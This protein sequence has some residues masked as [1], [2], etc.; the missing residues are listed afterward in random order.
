MPVFIDDLLSRVEKPARY[1]GGEMNATTKSFDDADVTFAFC[2]PDTYEVAMSHLGMKILYGILNDL[3]YALC[4][5]VCMPWTDMR[6][7]LKAAGRPLFSLESRHALNEFDIVGFT[8]QYEMSYTNILD[9][10]DMGGIPVRACDRKE[11]DPFVVAGGPCAFNPEPLW[12]FFDCFMIGDGEDSIVE[13]T[14]R[15]FPVRS[16]CAGWQSWK[17]CMCHPCTG[18]STTRTARSKA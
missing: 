5:R 1:T 12:E 3:P 17:A 14:D 13:V 2:F 15:A 10:L 18:T 4:E 9:M 7:E 16:V 11:S 6:R 8:L